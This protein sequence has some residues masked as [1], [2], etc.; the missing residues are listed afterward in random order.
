MNPKDILIATA[1]NAAGVQ[2]KRIRDALKAD[3]KKM[4]MAAASTETGQAL[5]A[6]APPEAQE[7]IINLVAEASS[8]AKE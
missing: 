7:F 1:R 3:L 4:A 6:A 5:L 8:A 2:A